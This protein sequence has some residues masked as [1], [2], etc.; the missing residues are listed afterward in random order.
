MESIYWYVILASAAIVI[1]AFGGLAIYYRNK[2]KKCKTTLIRYIN[3]NIEMKEKLPE[4]E[5]PNFINSEEITPSEFS[6][7]MTNVMKRLLFIA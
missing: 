3:E 6:R 5:L 7:I 2:L 1:I 4:Y